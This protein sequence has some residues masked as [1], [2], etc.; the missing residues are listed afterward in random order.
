MVGVGSLEIAVSAE[1]PLSKS[2]ILSVGDS[3]SGSL[4]TCP[5]SSIES[6]RANRS[7]G[8][9]MIKPPGSSVAT[10]N[11]AVKTLLLPQRLVEFPSVTRDAP[12][13]SSICLSLAELA[14]VAAPCARFERRA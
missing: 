6:M 4:Q 3:D 2:N 8:N 10:R 1:Q 12:R 13:I 7:G 5:R 11:G 14:S 9:V